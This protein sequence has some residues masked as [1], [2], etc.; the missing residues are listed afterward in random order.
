MRNM[1][2]YSNITFITN[3]TITPYPNST[4]LALGNSQLRPVLTDTGI[5][6]NLIGDTE[7][8]A[9]YLYD[10]FGSFF[11]G[12]QL[13]F[14]RDFF[15]HSLAY[16]PNFVSVGGV[17]QCPYGFIDAVLY[18]GSSFVLFPQS[19]NIINQN[20]E[21]NPIFMCISFDCIFPCENNGTRDAMGIL[22]NGCACNCSHPWGG[23][24]CQG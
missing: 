17:S 18:Y 7:S 23:V 8:P 19:I 1:L 4:I 12:S 24:Y 15:L 2:E 21:P 20:N 16:N 22:D 10:F 3:A 6:Y 9:Y 14:V 5:Q 11:N 13:I